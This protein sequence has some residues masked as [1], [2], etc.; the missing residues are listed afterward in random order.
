MDVL[1]PLPNRVSNT[2]I[3]KNVYGPMGLEINVS[4]SSA[5]EQSPLRQDRTEQNVKYIHLR[6]NGII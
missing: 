3:G 1:N 6:Q 5:I 4:N 2:Q